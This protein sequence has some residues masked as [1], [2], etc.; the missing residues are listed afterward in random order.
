MY[1]N[2]EIIW[3]GV[4][5]A[6]IHYVLGNTSGSRSIKVSYDISGWNNRTRQFFVNIVSDLSL[7]RWYSR[8][9]KSEL[10]YLHISQRKRVILVG[11]NFLLI[12]KKH[13]RNFQ[14]T[15]IVLAYWFSTLQNVIQS[16]HCNVIE[17]RFSLH[18]KKGRRNPHKVST[19]LLI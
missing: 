7:V 18:L 2:Y 11:N 8:T 14:R 4:W 6:I 13:V 10:T 9:K 17:F 15:F 16:L 3:H 1:I 12:K 19:K 5:H